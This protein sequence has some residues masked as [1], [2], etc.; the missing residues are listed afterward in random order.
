MSVLI[1]PYTSSF[2]KAQYSRSS[3]QWCSVKNGFLKNTCVGI[4]RPA[5]LLKRDFNTGFSCEIYETFKNTYFEEDL[6]TTTCRISKLGVI[7]QLLIHLPKN[8][9]SA[10]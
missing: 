1:R 8:A 9:K 10:L 4:F 2:A 5:T 6:R 7:S 3:H